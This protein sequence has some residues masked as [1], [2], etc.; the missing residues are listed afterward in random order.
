MDNRPG[1]NILY[2][3]LFLKLGFSRQF[4]KSISV[5]ADPDKLPSFMKTIV[6]ILTF[7]IDSKKVPI[8][9][10]VTNTFQY[11]VGIAHFNGL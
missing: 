9:L 6:T 4:L 1:N 11:I 8:G 5:L 3:V 10:L 7:G 2:S